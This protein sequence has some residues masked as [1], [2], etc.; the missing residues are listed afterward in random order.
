MAK[1]WVG[2]L[3]AGERFVNRW[4]SSTYDEGARRFRCK[5]LEYNELRGLKEH[6][7]KANRQ[8]ENDNA[9]FEDDFHIM[10]M[11]DDIQLGHWKVNLD[12]RFRGCRTRRTPCI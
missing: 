11:I 10:R 9:D 3:L 7:G 6:H 2:T 12:F 1:N 4:I 8:N 5:P